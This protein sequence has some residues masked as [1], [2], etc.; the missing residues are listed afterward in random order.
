MSGNGPNGGV[1]GVCN[2]ASSALSSKTTTLNSTACFT[3][4]NACSTEANLLVIAG[5]GGGGTNQ[6]GGGGGGGYRF[7]TAYPLASCSAYK[8]TVGGG[9]VG[10]GPGSSPTTRGSK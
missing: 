8:V 2:A 4:G 7:C 9:G 3:R 5:G 6:S 10:A 1:I